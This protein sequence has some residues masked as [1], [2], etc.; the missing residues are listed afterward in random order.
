[1]GV[2]R[3]GDTRETDVTQ[4]EHWFRFQFGFPGALR[5][6]ACKEPRQKYTVGSVKVTA[7]TL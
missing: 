4:V 1:M 7:K 5:V 2:H 3:C 6:R